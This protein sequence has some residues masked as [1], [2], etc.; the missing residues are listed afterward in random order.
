M[1][2]SKKLK[3]LTTCLVVIL[4]AILVA[5]PALAAAIVKGDSGSQVTKI[6]E[7]LKLWGY[8]TG[9]VDGIFGSSTEKAVKYFQRTNGLTADGIVGS[10]T[11][12]AL[13][14]TIKSSGSG[15]LSS[16]ELNLLAHLVYAEARGEPYTGQVAVAAVVLNR[17]DSSQFPNSIS[18]VAYQPGAFSCVNDGQINLTPDAEAIRAAKDALNGWDPSGGAI[19]YYNPDIATDN[20]I[21]TR[22]IIARIGGHV[23]AV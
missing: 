5:T 21:R 2:E 1:L 8:Y 18:G 20:W 11:G 6:Q 3:L 14:I 16:S 10:A 13:G 12:R 17:V 9:A 15:G 7:R 23:F 19:F 22:T 4:I